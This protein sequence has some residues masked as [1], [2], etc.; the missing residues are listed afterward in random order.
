MGLVSTDGKWL[1]VNSELCEMLGYT[2]QELL[3]IDFQTITYKDDLESNLEHINQMLEGTIRTYKMEKR[4][5]KK[6]GG[7]IWINLSVSLARYPNGE[8]MYFISQIE[9]ITERKLAE[10][11]LQ[12]ALEKRKELEFIVNRSAVIVFLWKAEEGWP[13][14][15][16]SENIEQFGY[17]QQDFME[18]R[19]PYA[20]I[21]HSEDVER[22]GDEVSMYS[23]QGVNEY[24]QEFRII[25][26]SG[27]VRWTEDH[28]W[29]R[30]DPD[31]NITHYQGIVVDVTERKQAEEKL[32]T[33]AEDLKH[34]N[35]L[36]DMFTD[37]LRHDLLNPAGLVK[38]FTEVLIERENDGDK[39]HALQKIEQNNKK[40]ID[41]IESA[42]K[43]AKLESTDEFEFNVKDIGTIFKD[44]VEDFAPIL[45]EKQ[46][47]LDFV[48]EGEHLANVNPIIEEVFANLL[49]NAITDRSNESIIIVDILNSVEKWK[50]KGLDFGEGITD[51]DKPNIFTRFKRVGKGSVKGTGLGLAIVK[52]IVELHG[53]KVGVEDN[54]AGQGS[55]FWVTV[56][57]G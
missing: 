30:R 20:D 24:S 16:V 22:V 53:G 38:G 40:L 35:E 36:K 45:Y 27:D 5:I 34:A 11:L 23:E 1:K 51:D 4:Y 26:R 15:F 29:I 49:S 32:K 31:G 44:V 7:I 47:T 50:V 55:M 25:T 14:E 10:E 13:V 9:N 52:K 54:P 2:E 6:D 39:L 56:R 18:G 19:I 42:A 33:Y 3:A 48:A 28:T 21:I 8:P 57:K 37:I 46:I 41:L 12:V 43:V 17:T